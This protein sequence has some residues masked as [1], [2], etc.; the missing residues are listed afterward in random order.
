MDNITK[1]KQV[2]FII[3]SQYRRKVLEILENPKMPSKISKELNIDKAHISK[4]LKE[5]EKEKLI[6][7]LTPNSMKGKLYAITNYG[8][9]ILNE[10]TNL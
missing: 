8:K 7:C 4:T 6:K 1:W 2:S 3:S 5:L 9:D 10:T